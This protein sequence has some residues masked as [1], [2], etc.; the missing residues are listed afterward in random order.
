MHCSFVPP[1]PSPAVPQIKRAHTQPPFDIGRDTIADYA[2]QVWMDKQTV[3]PSYDWATPGFAAAW[4]PV[5][6]ATGQSISA[7]PLQAAS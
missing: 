2:G 5:A 7:S 4:V 1:S 6:I 3:A